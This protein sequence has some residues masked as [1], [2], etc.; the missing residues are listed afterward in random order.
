MPLKLDPTYQQTIVHKIDTIEIIAFSIDL[1]NLTVS[2]GWWEGWIDANNVFQKVNEKWATLGATDTQ[3]A[4]QRANQ[5][6]STQATPDVYGAIKQALYE[7]L[8]AITG[9]KGTVV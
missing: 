1:Q 9:V 7:K 8:Q 3:A 5:I 4:I 6:V 2:V